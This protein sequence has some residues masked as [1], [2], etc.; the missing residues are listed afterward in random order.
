MTELIPGAWRVNIVS[1]GFL[2]EGCH[3]VV[4]KADS[5][6]FYI[7]EHLA[8]DFL[9]RLHDTYIQYEPADEEFDVTGLEFKMGDDSIAQVTG[10]EAFDSLIGRLNNR[11]RTF[12][13]LVNE[14]YLTDTRV[15][16]FRNK[17]NEA[18]EW[19]KEAA[20]HEDFNKDHAKIYAESLEHLAEPDNKLWADRNLVDQN[21][22]DDIERVELMEA[23]RHLIIEHASKMLTSGYYSS[24]V[25]QAYRDARKKFKEQ[26]QEILDQKAAEEPT[27]I[28][29]FGLTLDQV[30]FDLVKGYRQGVPQTLEQAVQEIIE[31]LEEPIV[32]GTFAIDG[33]HKDVAGIEQSAEGLSTIYWR[34]GSQTA[35][36]ENGQ[37]IYYWLDDSTDDEVF[38]TT[39]K[40]YVKKMFQPTKWKLGE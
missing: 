26:R 12:G 29:A 30:E 9:D 40:D 11:W 2:P 23:S 20:G 18:K 14:H 37:K 21:V 3:G 35:Y 6:D 5:N 32:T 22:I 39:F 16:E 38:A 7:E 10:V 19:M 28:P 15:E 34:D 4:A 13:G 33:L 17:I 36:D 8:G 1:K 31:G 27:G 24:D 25:S